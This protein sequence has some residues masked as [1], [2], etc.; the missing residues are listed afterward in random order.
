[1]SVQVIESIFSEMYR[2][3]GGF[4][5]ELLARLLVHSSLRSILSVSTLQVAT[6]K[7]PLSFLV[8]VTPSLY[9]NLVRPF[10]ASI[11]TRS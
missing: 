6:T 4:G 1:M 10:T 7:L 11:S 3:H 8:V 5:E 2:S 9:P